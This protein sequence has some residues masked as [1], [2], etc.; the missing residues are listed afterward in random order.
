MKQ[1]CYAII[2]RSDAKALRGK[3]MMDALGTLQNLPMRINRIN[4]LGMGL[5]SQ[6]EFRGCFPLQEA[7]DSIR[8]IANAP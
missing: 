4:V 1:G 8:R 2:D 3:P 6:M 7:L 5:L